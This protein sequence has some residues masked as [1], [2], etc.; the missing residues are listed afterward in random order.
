[1]THV[2]SMRRGFHDGNHNPH[3]I[4]GGGAIG[5]SYK[6]RGSMLLL[7]V[8]TAEPALARGIHDQE[9]THMSQGARNTVSGSEAG[10]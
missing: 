7:T 4:R 10:F 2:Q 8:C 3:T 9:G 1:M 5:D 6:Q